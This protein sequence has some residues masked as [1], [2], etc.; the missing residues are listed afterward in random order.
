MGVVNIDTPEELPESGPGPSQIVSG[1]RLL[2]KD[3]PALLPAFSWP[4]RP[5]YVAVA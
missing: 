3:A 4:T 1:N 2:A 5:R